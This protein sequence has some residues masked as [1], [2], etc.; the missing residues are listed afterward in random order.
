VSPY[1]PPPMDLAT[2]V[3]YVRRFVWKRAVTAVHVH[4][5]WQPNHQ[6]WAGA[7]S[8]TAMRDYHV[9]VNKWSDIAQHVTID[10]DGMIWIGRDWNKAPAS[11]AGYNGT[12]TRG[13]FMFE[14]VG[15]FD[16]GN[17][18]LEGAQRGS[19]L[20]VTATVQ[21]QFLL[22]ANTMRFHRQLGSPKTCPGTS[23]DY[24]V[25]LA[26]LTDYREACP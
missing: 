26:E 21:K 24:D 20:G 23:V 13:P 4:H 3:E 8:I 22:P 16:T 19:V 9:N 10:P 12:G 25:L 7:R 17:D 1:P 18:V 11:S 6:T 2:F 15:N 5:T 14:T